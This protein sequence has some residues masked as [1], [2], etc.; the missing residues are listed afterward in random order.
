MHIQKSVSQN[1][2]GQ[3]PEFIRDNS[4]LLEAFLKSYYRSQEKTGKPLDI[5]NNI[6]EYFDVNSYDLKQI[7]ASSSL[8]DQVELDQTASIPVENVDGFLNE[9][10]TI[11]INDEVIYY[12]RTTS[13]PQVSFSSGI[14][15][16]E[17]LK[18]KIT[19]FS[20]YQ[21]FD[22]VT[23]SF[24]LLSNNE[25]V[26]PPSS[27]HLLIKLYGEYQVPGVHFNVVGDEIV[28][29]EAPRPFDALGEGDDAAAITFEYLKGFDSS[30]IQT[31]NLTPTSD[32][33]HFN[34]DYNGATVYP[35]SSYLMLVY[36]GPDLLVA[37]TDFS[38]FE[39]TLMLVEDPLGLPLN[40]FFINYN[41]LS[42]G[43]GATAYSVIDESGRLS[44][45]NVKSGGSSYT[46]ENTPTVNLSSSVGSYGSAKALV[47]G[48][49]QLTLLNGG[50]G[51]DPNNPPAVVFQSP[52]TIDGDLP[53]AIATVAS[54]GS[55]ESLEL[56]GSGSGYDFTPRVQFVN[57]TGAAVS[58]FATVGDNGNIVSVD[59]ISG[60]TNYTNPPR[61]YIE[62]PPSETGIPAVLQGVINDAGELVGVDI[63][64]AGTQYSV[65]NPPRTAVIQPTGA[66]ILNVDV[67]SFGRVINIAILY[68]GSGYDDVPSVYIIDDRKDN[69]GNPIG[70]SG[71]TAVATVFNGQIIDI[72]IT[73]FGTGYSSLEPPKVYI[74]EPIGAKASAVV[75]E[76]E[77]TGF[78][79]I[80]PGK[81]YQQSQ[82]VGCSRGVSGIVSYT[83]DNRAVFSNES[84]SIASV[85]PSGS[86]VKSLDSLFFKTVLRRIT[87][88][89]LPGLPEIDFANLNVS[90]VLTT[91]KDF[92]ASKG[93]QF[94]V[95]YLFNLLYSSFVEISY[96]KDQLIKPS[97]ASW[98]VDTVLRAKLISGNPLDL[99]NGLL[100]QIASDIDPNVG[101]AEALIENYIAI[102]T[103]QFDVYELTLS[104][105]SIVG[106]FTIPYK[107]KL[108][109]PLSATDIIITVDSTIGWPERNGEVIIGNELIRYKEKS[110]T[111]FIECT[112]G[113]NNGGVGTEWDPATTCESNFY[114]Y[115]NRG[116]A[117]EVVLSVLGIVEA[118]KT[119]LT[120][121][122][123]YY[124]PGDKLTIAKLGSTEDN[125]LLDSW[126][127][128][129]K[130]L[131][132]V[133]SVGY[134]GQNNQTATVETSEPHGLLIGDQ[135]TVYGANP[136]VYNGS[137]LV[138]S[139]PTRY[140]FTY[141]LP[142]PAN[143]VPQGNILISIDLNKGKS[144]STSINTSISRFASNVQ[145]TFFNNQHVY[146]ASSGIPN[147]KIGPFVGTALLP[148]NQRKLN[149]FPKVSNT[150]SLKEETKPGPIGTFVNGVSIWNYKS[151]TKLPY[152]PLTSIDIINGGTSYDAVVPPIITIAGGG[153]SDAE[154]LAVVNGS[155]VDIEVVNGG[156][157]YVS[158]PLVS[159]S[160]GGGDG[161][162][163]TAIITNG[164]V[165][166][167]LVKTSGTGFTSNPTVNIVGGG[168]GGATAVAVVRGPI[169]DVV[170]TN[171]GSDYTSSPEI[172][173]SSGEGAAAEA[174][175]SNGRITNIAIIASG[176]GYTTAPRVEIIG[177]GFG[178]IAKATISTEGADA[179]RVIGITI[180]NRGIGYG[181]SNT[182]IRL[183]SVGEGAS[184]SANIFEW[185]YNL[186]FNTNFDYANGSIFEGY[187]KQFGGEY[188]HLSNPTQLRYVLGDNLEVMDGE[189]MEK[190]DGLKHSPI[191]GWAFDGN[192]I[193]GPYGLTDPTNINSEIGQIRSGY[194]L[195]TNLI[196][197]EITNPNPVRVQGPL[198]SEYPAGYFIE[199]Y[200]FTF[201]SESIYLDQYNGRFTKTPEYP[202]GIYAYFVSITSAGLASF[203]YIIGPSF[204][205]V[206]D[207]WNLNQFAVQ[208]NI[209]TGIVRYRDPFENVDVDIERSANEQTNAIT[210]ENGDFLVFD[211]EDENRDGVISQDEIDDPDIVF[212][213]NKLQIFDY[214]PKIDVS[215]RVDIEVNTTTK[216]EDAKV[217]GFL[218]ENPG[219][220]YQVGDFL[221][222]DDSGTEG[223]GAS[224]AVDRIEGEAISSYTYEYSAA[225]DSYFGVITTSA[226]HNLEVGNTV[227][228]ETTPQMEPTSKTISMITVS[229]LEEIVVDRTG[230]GYNDDVPPVVEIETAVGSGAEVSTQPTTTGVIDT[231]NIIN[232]G[233]GYSS[234]NPPRIRISPPQVQARSNYY[235][236]LLLNG[237]SVIINK[238][239]SV[240]KNIYAVGHTVGSSGDTHGIILKLN[241]EGFLIWSKS[242]TPTVPSL[243]TKY[244]SF[245]SVVKSG[246][247]IYVVG[248][249]RPNPQ[250]SN[251]FNPDIILAKWEENITGTDAT[252]SWQRGFAGISGVNRADYA[253]DLAIFGEGVVVCGYT[254]TN[255]SHTFDAL[256][257]YVDKNAS[258]ITR[259]KI[260]SLSTEDRFYQVRVSSSNGIYLIGKALTNIYVAHASFVGNKFSVNWS[261]TIS[262][263]NLDIEDISAVI[264]D[265]DEIYI[266]GTY[267]DTSTSTRNKMVVVKLSSDATVKFYKSITFPNT[268]TLKATPA[269]YDIFDVLNIGASVIDTNGD[270]VSYFAKIK[271][272]GTI[273]NVNKLE[274]SGNGEGIT[275]T[276][277]F[278]DVSGDPVVAS[279]I[280]RNR[281]QFLYNAE[282][283]FE[284]ATTRSEDLSSSGTVNLS[285][286]A[287][288]GSGS[289][290]ITQ[291]AKL[292]AGSITYTSATWTLENWVKWNSASTAKLPILIR[293][294]DGVNGVKVVVY[295]DSTD[296]VNYGKVR[297]SNDSES[298]ND[299][300]TATT[301]ISDLTAGWVHIALTKSFANGVNTYKLFWNGT[302]VA[303]IDETVAD[304]NPTTIEFGSTT[305]GSS[306]PMKIDDVRYSN[307]L[308]YTGSQSVPAAAHTVFNFSASGS[309]LMKFDKNADSVRLGT[310]GLS[311]S[312]LSL[313]RSE[314][315]ATLLN[316]TP[317]S[318]N[319][320]L[321]T[322][323]YQVLDY[324]DAYTGLTQNSQSP[325]YT[326]EIW[327]TRTATIPSPGGRKPLFSSRAYDKFFFK[328]FTTSKI[329]NVYEFVLNQSFVFTPGS[330][331]TQVSNAG[332]TLASAKVM[333]V[334]SNNTIYLS[335]LVGTFTND[336]YRLE[337]SNQ[338]VNDIEDYL[339]A[340]IINTTPGTFVLTIPPELSAVFK[341]Y[342]EDDYLVRIDETIAGSEYSRGSVYAL[343]SSFFSFNSDYT[344][345]TISGL[346]SVTQIS[347]T[348]NL[349][350]IL[351]PTSQSL[352]NQLYVATA[353]S[354]YLNDGD[355]INIDNSVNYPQALGT[356]YVERII[357]KREFLYRAATTPGSAIASGTTFSVYSK[358]PIF[359]FI[360]GQQ[361]TFDTSHPSNYGHYLSFYED[362]L[363][364]IE[365]T[366]KNIVRR[367]TPGLD[368]PGNSP[369]ISFKVTDDVSSISYYAD[370]SRLES[371][372]PIGNNSYIDIVR[373]PYIGE[374]QISE[375][376]G[377]TITTGANEFK[378]P[379]QY[380]PE[381]AA[382]AGNSKYTTSS[383]KAVGSIASIRL[384][385]GGGFYTKLPIITDI[386]SSRKIERVDILSP[387]TEYADGEYFGVPIL[388]DGTGGRV[389]LRVDGTTDPAGQIV[390]VTVTD[391]GKGYTEAYIDVD[392]VDGILG[393]TLAGSGAELSVVI[394]PF[395]TGASVFVTG[396]R[397]GKIKN[398][399]NNNFGFDYTP[400]Y[401]LRPEITFPV[402]LQL[403]STSVLSGIQVIDPGTGYTS[404]PEVVIV[405][406]GGSGATAEAVL[407]NGRINGII[408]KN[409][410]SGYTTEPSVE[411]KSSF[412]YV[413]NL[414]LGLFQFAFP[415][416]IQNGS[417]VTFEVQD[418]G[419]GTEFPLTSFG[420]LNPNQIYYAVAG[421]S[422]GL[423]DDQLRIALTPQDAETGSYISFV[424]GGQGRQIVLTDSFGGLAEATLETAR[425]LSGETV[426]QGET[427]ETATAVGYVSTNDGWQIG[428]RLLKLVNYTGD[429]EIGQR[430]TGLI[431]KASGTIGEISIA[432]GVLE[433]DSTTKT[434]GKF[435]DDIGKPSEIVQKVQDSYLYQLF[436]YNIKSPISIDQ[437]R[438]TVIDNIHP[439]GFKIFGE[440]GI[441]G[442]GKG[443]TDKTDFELV[444]SVNL[445][446]SSVVSN[447]DNF[448]LVEPV[449][450]EFDNTQ[451]LF[452]NKRL[453]SSEEILTSVVQKLDNIA[454]LF[455]GE[456]TVFPLTIDGVPV[457]AQASQFM[458]IINGIAQ[459]P[460]DAFSVQ[461]GSIIFSE[462]PS[463]PTKVSY[464]NLELEFLTTQSLGITNDSGIFPELGNS[465]RGLVSGASGTVLTATT[466]ELV[467]FNV[468]GTFEVGESI[469][470]SATGFNA[471]ITTI[472]NNTNANVFEFRE[473]ITNLRKKTAV[474]EEINLDSV[475]NIT[476]NQIVI[477][478]TSGTYDS[479]AGLLDMD[480]NDYI[481]S[482]QTGIVA[483]IS[484]ISAY[485]DPNTY[486][487]V[488]TADNYPATQGTFQQGELFTTPNGATGRILF[489][490]PND[491]RIIAETLSGD[492]QSLD[493]ITG[494]S[495][496][497]IYRILTSTD[498]DPTSSVTIS[499]PSEF[500]GLLFNRIVSPTNPNVIIDDISKSSVEVV[501]LDDNTRKAESSFLESEEVENIVIDYENATSP[502]SIGDLIQN[503]KI[504]YRNE[505]AAF[506]NG[507][508]LEVRKLTYY[509]L[510]N[511]NYQ[512]GDTIT[513]LN[514]GASANVIGINYALK[515][516][517]LGSV[518]GTFQIG[519]TITADKSV[520]NDDTDLVSGRYADAS[521]LILA[522]KLLIAEEAVDRMLGAFP[523]FSVPGGNQNCV[524]D[525]VDVLGELCFNLKYGGNHRIYD[526][527]LLYINN[528]YLQ[529][530]RDESVYAFNQARDMA[531]Q[532]MRNE[533]ITING[534]TTETQVKDLTVEVDPSNPT[535][536]DVASSITTLVAI[537]TQAIGDDT[538]GAGNLTGITRTNSGDVSS[539]I[540]TEFTIPFTVQGIDSG[541]KTITTDQYFNDTQHRF[542]DAANLL[543][544]NATYIIEESHGRMKARY[545][546]LVIP[547]DEDGSGSGSERCK[548][549]LS[550]LLSAVIKDL[551]DGGD[552]NTVNAGRYYIDSSGGL[553]F[554]ATQVL[555]S[556]YAHLQMS[557]LCQLAVSGQ[558]SEQPLYTDRF[559]I[560]PID[561]TSDAGLCAD[562]RSAIDVLWTKINDIIAPTGQV[563]RD[564]G[565]LIWFNRSFIADEAIAYI[566]DYFTYELNGITYRA[567]EYP[568]GTSE[569][570]RRDLYDYILPAIIS[571]LVSG[572]DSNI[573]EAMKYY[574]GQSGADV[575]YI[576]NELLPTVVAIEKVNELCQYAVNNWEITGST[577]TYTTQYGISAPQYTDLSITVDD[578]TYGGDCSRIKSNI[579]SL[580][581]KGIDILIPERDLAT[582]EINL[583]ADYQDI[584]TW[585]S[586]QNLTVASNNQTAPDGT[587]GAYT[588]SL[589]N[590]SNT[591]VRLRQNFS[592]VNGH[593][594][595]F[596]FYAKA[597][598]VNTVAVFGDS[599]S[600]E[601]NYAN[602][603][604]YIN[605]STG[606]IIGTVRTPLAVESVGNGWWKISQSITADGSTTTGFS[607]VPKSLGNVNNIT[608]T[609]SDNIYIW[610]PTLIDNTAD[611]GAR[612]YDAANLIESNK[613][614]IAEEAVDRMLAAYPGFS[615]PNGNQNCIDDIVDVLGT[616]IYDLRYGGNHKTYDAA[617]IYVSGQYV[618]GEETQSVYAFEEARDMAIQAMRNETITITGST[619]QTQVIDNTVIADTETPACANVASAI[620]TLMGIITDAIST[621]SLAGI[622][623]TT[624]SSK[625]VAFRGAAKLLLFNK[626]YF[627]YESL[628]KTLNNYQGFSIPGGNSK[629]L[630]DMGYIIDAVV[631][632]LLTYGNGAMYEATTAYIDAVTGTIS[633]LEGELAESIY[634]Y[635]EVR[636]LMFKA[637]GET[638]SS[639][640]PNAGYYAYT[641]SDISLTGELLTEIQ[642]FVHNLFEMLLGT[643][644]NPTFIDNYTPYNSIVLPDI[645]YP[646]RE[647]YTPVLGGLSV[648]DYIYGVSSGQS[649][650]IG[651]ITVN[652][653]YVK[654][655]IQRFEITLTN[656]L[657]IFYAGDELTVPS[658]ANT[659]TV[660]STD[661]RENISYIDVI[662]TNGTIGATNI[663]E[664]EN[665]FTATV[666]V[667]FDRVQVINLTG[668]FE[669]GDYA[670]SP[671]SDSEFSI[672]NFENNRS[673]I[674]SNTGGR[675]TL[676]TEFTY[677][678]LDV[679]RVLYSSISDY[680][681]DV[682]SSYEGLQ[683]GIGDI[684][685]TTKIYKIR[686]TLP[687]TNQENF[688]VGGTIVN[689]L[690]GI[691]QSKS[692]IIIAQ[693]VENNDNYIYYQNLLNDNNFSQGEFVGYYETVGADAT[694]YGEIL[695]VYEV[696]SVGFGTVERVIQIGNSYRLYLS[697]V[698]G[699]FQQYAQVV[700]IDYRTSVVS[701][702]EIVGRVSRSFRGFDGAQTQ[703]KL[704]IN[705]GTPYLPDPDGYLLTFINGVLQPAGDSFSAFS[706]IIAF[707]EPPELGSTFHAVYM[708]KLRQLD[709][710]AFEFDSLSS[711]FNLKLNDV[712]YSLT[713]TEG[714]Q[715]TTIKP[716]NNII[717]SL[718]GVIQEPGVAFEIVGS[719]INFAEIPRAG[720]SFVAYSYIGSDADVV[721]AT[722]VPPI[723]SGDKLEIEGEDDERTVALVESSNSLVTF[724]YLGS[725]FGRNASALTLLK[726]G[727]IS[728]VQLTSGGD[729]YTSRPTVS[730]NSST[731]FDATI[732]ALVGIARIDV[733]D[734]GSNYQYP[735]ITVNTDVPDIVG[736]GT[737][738]STGGTFDNTGA[739]FDAT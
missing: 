619:T 520:M 338:V 685:K 650:E 713:I 213:E 83:V 695:E 69:I 283:A 498:I 35:S 98:S 553:R 487:V 93:T 586:K 557:D 558:L 563:Y 341:P 102:Q 74:S 327:S 304:M 87:N 323:G 197:N 420:F 138:T 331:I 691:V 366:F 289:Y 477:S 156:S 673:P 387:G 39:N 526:A 356:Y 189:L 106:L 407:R 594:Y 379:I 266:T 686:V 515:T 313:S 490:Y 551:E 273:I 699:V 1:L 71:A 270:R 173:L 375:L 608:A 188:A 299:P 73:D 99:T 539:T 714:S 398:L 171:A 476:T 367:G 89:Y 566:D 683:I 347:V 465:V 707:T 53:S 669:D 81:N 369:Y 236:T 480:I 352:T 337:S 655:L 602:S 159:I 202:D 199:D 8:I 665:G 730:I 384:V 277:V 77:V 261:K 334:G 478:K 349:K 44:K 243:E 535:C 129:V 100:E 631:Y 311:S 443:L 639:P 207:S 302:E 677:G 160:G 615:V 609:T 206:P 610:G 257:M 56:L 662:I 529:D 260:T 40:A 736:G 397:I 269:N 682:F 324:S 271:Y 196:Y 67:D 20:P 185:T 634:A 234:E 412:T 190:V 447:I 6:N 614:L 574:V 310:I 317:T 161:A 184:F 517:F 704:T 287:K 430:I 653:A 104:E 359:K 12:E 727:R 636:D 130:K 21:L 131:L 249:T 578:G 640:S 122:G 575:A 440:I 195:K 170:I 739:T 151:D 343:G 600:F 107:T 238:M 723:E 424:N 621:N 414:D 661:Y 521:D 368:E 506:T 560:P 374:F 145:N 314:S 617:Q 227:F 463:A 305:T 452:R 418:L 280:Y 638:L 413:V 186:Q 508:V 183:I 735:S 60:G 394:P 729:G 479:P 467:V 607:I 663:L 95:K 436:S 473:K 513:G 162:T 629:C 555:Q 648:G 583:F 144:D 533:T 454:T 191:I 244:C 237:T 474:V 345:L 466:S 23:Q 193:Y 225:T 712:F 168:G 292:T 218:I 696:D 137:F 49:K 128:N 618:S 276:A 411:L 423:E 623:R 489:W 604:V 91:A 68:G 79:I 214:F 581:I 468:T 464:A 518:T 254:N 348:A 200:E 221:V 658:T 601:P 598:T 255:S 458:I 178:A 252:L 644:N 590:I 630:R 139:I 135:V 455:D 649:G 295:G 687:S 220:N 328:V 335:S 147:Y 372:R 388:G 30:L 737:W 400:D 360:I 165:S 733:V 599:T 576:K 585:G 505:T 377:A 24:K 500:F 111:Q 399:K 703:F 231:I 121:D 94:A 410:G 548:L 561:I 450:S 124:L 109:E 26:F 223:Y 204:Y 353:T 176:S 306:W 363:N 593:T 293:A 670:R 33:R 34:L 383:P 127:Y 3:I 239:I 54:N 485:R 342:N 724:D 434:S 385:S 329:D 510:S 286:D 10:G 361:Y 233:S 481:Y 25:P 700:G 451:V 646:T 113:I 588:V 92:Y 17:F 545:P 208:S 519:E 509:S 296:T 41:M 116:T 37:N 632:D 63:L 645:V 417:E 318:G 84:V 85:H 179:G 216:F 681:I 27:N 425:F 738:D 499:D 726:N 537:L 43:S 169:A 112:R 544:Q 262:V 301:Y 446:E 718:N 552:Y 731:G 493:V 606:A 132:Q 415:H 656:E 211:V 307:Y 258:T 445:I 486:I 285:V 209:P 625:N 460:G 381:K 531:I 659:C 676:D 149:R 278:G 461:S 32:S 29:T 59:V 7:N 716:E 419:E 587:T 592:V 256:M 351:Q 501:S 75:G 279:Q 667:V 612:Y 371:E 376:A 322:E 358:H 603:G 536:A 114:V 288:F 705:N 230:I 556:V 240:D 697:G 158:S 429:F 710:I 241:A 488:D 708:G 357:N 210:L 720:S 597:G 453:T 401:T 660:F 118:N 484:K 678:S 51:Y 540:S 562:V 530:E 88:Q 355:I 406:G 354:H 502:L 344:E 719:R 524:D 643:L 248:N 698:K 242:L 187:N 651:S 380:D 405:G 396:D 47:N 496:N 690:G 108:A 495:S 580:F 180:V 134:G 512:L 573:V 336:N 584:T 664:S 504:E 442:G 370:P 66:Q 470:V 448:A 166:R 666:D 589:G 28:F 167:I 564:A 15:L 265:Y 571:D 105:E 62:N 263:P 428:P 475:N 725:I 155:I 281:T 110:L 507:E 395:G 441:V 123:K 80:S 684:I 734:R 201:Q 706:D 164:A 522:N 523:G 70:G 319:Y 525:I 42:V 212:E 469:I 133:E 272:D 647:L 427:I 546:D 459:A 4:P 386:Q 294:T 541:I 549:D 728:D 154:A 679:S 275:T 633:S 492:F 78:A 203:P 511:G 174:Y 462:P 267:H 45:I 76:G 693:T 431:S 321:A 642:E 65:E 435:I 96:P 626:E 226:P 140:T 232:S 55:I 198:L 702:S 125:R 298:I 534:S 559:P 153:G 264:D 117:S 391:P 717:V 438:Q 538:S 339:F 308:V 72:N 628:Q 514:S 471:N 577:Q 38:L 50:T 148:G 48:V 637:L 635:T 596:S 136:I 320:N 404:P 181:D 115:V 332:A 613:Q 119:I 222:F 14:S 16:S 284:D 364:K 641:D 291:D 126:L 692:A 483:R 582:E 389:S 150:I 437:W 579:D 550:L 568:G 268:S 315:S 346:A 9:D 52:T 482:A 672:T 303:S 527:G 101:V 497:A 616:I 316:I 192:P 433:V 250:L 624:D 722:V 11:L 689:V 215:S 365:Y 543:R 143:I 219:I 259:R 194:S 31:L 675:L 409:P 61:I 253:T 671:R 228:V 674:I 182:Q 668:E 340:S 2:L 175:V 224:G 439:A 141:E 393:P 620:T 152:G 622:V 142:A 390:E 297:L 309:L 528:A 565:D 274:S 595:T 217:S 97:S 157:G 19:L 416:G 382:I 290:E 146:V 247:T 103:P 82:F 494:A 456:R 426:F 547:G 251:T 611:S 680:Y 362:N 172:T 654:H 503:Y 46:V 333:S 58:T 402:N 378:F 36:K 542:R 569:T 688:A 13:A 86:S 325:T 330:T 403:T 235:G 554:I 732:K 90:N 392:A 163:A 432:K 567:F 64:N 605:L 627:K 472:T 532:A 715:S 591:S 18:K 516:L 449:Y 246:T 657:Q 694:G 711:S 205:S 229:G 491:R 570:C 177:D 721:A 457:I 422:A 326:T 373:S 444:K 350:K 5:I 22:G 652:R 701:A 709:N 312:N 57:P 120:D 282:T 421:I 245:V 408:I 300:T 572:G